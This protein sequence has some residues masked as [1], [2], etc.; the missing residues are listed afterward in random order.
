MQI[1]V[2]SKTLKVTR[3]LRQF[4]SDQ[5]AKLQKPNQRISKVRISLDQPAK[6]T[7]RDRN[8]LVK[9]VVSLPGK[10]VVMKHKAHD[11]YEAIVETTDKVVRQ[12]R[13]IKEKRLDQ[14]RK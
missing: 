1:Q 12:V 11:M 4:A 7:K 8:A 6:G 5:A 3:A 14:L 10:T 2:A 9:Y 13:K